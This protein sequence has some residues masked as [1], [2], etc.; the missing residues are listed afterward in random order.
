ML[1]FQDEEAGISVIH[2]LE[3]NQK[4][5]GILFNVNS[6]LLFLR[7]LNTE[8]QY[9]LKQILADMKENFTF[10]NKANTG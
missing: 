8:L 9:L 7:A 10:T 5:G 3:E 1:C 4:F 6:N 2:A